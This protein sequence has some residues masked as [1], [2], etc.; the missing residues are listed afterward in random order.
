MDKRQ[1]PR[2]KVRNMHID[3]SDGIGACSGTVH[4]I[5]RSGLCLFDLPA[6]VGRKSASYTVVVSHGDR[7]FKFRVRPRWQTAARLYKRMGV[8]IADPPARWRDYVHALEPVA[9]R[10]G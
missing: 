7:L 10:N 3:V 2:I 8:E 5:S 9:R 4:D 1:Y 6:R